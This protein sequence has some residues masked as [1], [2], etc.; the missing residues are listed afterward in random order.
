MQHE[1][2]QGTVKQPVYFGKFELISLELKVQ[3]DEVTGKV[4]TIHTMGRLSF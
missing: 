2:I 4:D 1:Q 3:G